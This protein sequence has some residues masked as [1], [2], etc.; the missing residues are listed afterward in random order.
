VQAVSLSFLALGIST[1][2]WLINIIVELAEKLGSKENLLPF[3]MKF[4]VG[5]D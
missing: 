5:I 1:T 3:I 2:L 4:P